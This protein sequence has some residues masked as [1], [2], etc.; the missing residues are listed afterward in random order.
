MINKI[1]LSSA[2][3]FM[4]FLFNQHAYSAEEANMAIPLIGTKL[5][6]EPA[7]A[8]NSAR[9]ALRNETISTTN[10]SVNKPDISEG[11]LISYSEDN[12][13]YTYVS[14]AAPVAKPRV[15]YYPHLFYKEFF[16][17]DNDSQPIRDF[18]YYKIKTQPNYE[19][20]KKNIPLRD[21]RFDY[22]KNK[23]YR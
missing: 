20:K 22:W 10:V 23:E 17:R 13:A 3:I 8:D 7:T 9:T 14:P 15:P 11:L 16:Y 21:F 4:L 6:G 18:R 19:Y 1:F 12:A 2:V 5:S